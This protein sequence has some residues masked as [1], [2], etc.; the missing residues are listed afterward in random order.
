MQIVKLIY[1]IILVFTI[2]AASNVMA[3]QEPPPLFT[4]TYNLFSSGLEIAHMERNMRQQ[5]EHE[6]IYSS[7]TNTVGLVAVFHKD[8]IVEESRWK[9]VNNQVRPLTYNYLRT[10]G[11]KDR[12]I[13]IQFDWDNKLIN[14]VVNERQ[15]Q[16]PL[17]E[18]ILDKLL[19]QYALMRDLMNNQQEIAY[20]V[21]DG[22]KMKKYNFVRMED[23]IVHTPLGDLQTVKLQKIK[24]DDASKLVI[25]SAPSLRYLPVKVE[26]TDED[27]TTTT[28][29]IQTLVWM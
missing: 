4:A 15:R 14:N 26:S 1:C 23:E 3:D 28:A 19:Y 10:R 8:H 29:I 2:A 5:G 18:G 11:K 22:G 7:N 20:D 9:L 13:N 6:Y 24:H 27:G 25:W 12:R 21:T 16:M 17:A